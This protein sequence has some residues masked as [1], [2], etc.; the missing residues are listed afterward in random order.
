MAL[1]FMLLR[2]ASRPAISVPARV[3]S[4][5]AACWAQAVD[6]Y[7]LS[8][9]LGILLVGTQSTTSTDSQPL[10]SQTRLLVRLGINVRVPA[11][12]PDSMESAATQRTAKCTPS[13]S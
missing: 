3:L 10:D 8:L 1:S 4:P 11:R 5:I 2:S 9:I 7:C 12:A 13:T 6:A